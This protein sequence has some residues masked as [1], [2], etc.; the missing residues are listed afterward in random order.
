MEEVSLSDT[1]PTTESFLQALNS[2]G[3]KC[4]V[5]KLDQKWPLARYYLRLDPK[6][7]YSKL[8]SLVEDIALAM[9]PIAPPVIRPSF[10]D[11]LVIVEMMFADHPLVEFESIYATADT[12]AMP[13][14]LG[15]T[16]IDK[17]LVVDVVALPHMIV[18][19]T[20]GSG[21]SMLLHAII[22]SLTR[23]YSSVGI[24]LALIDPK[25]VEFDRYSKHPSL[26]YPVVNDVDLAIQ[27]LE[28]LKE[29]MTNR[30]K[31]FQKYKCTNITEYRQTVKKIPYIVVVV[32][33]LAD[34][35]K[36]KQFEKMLCELAQ[37]G[38]AAGIHL[39][40]ATQHPSSKVLTGEIR[41][42]FPA[43]IACKVTTR[44]HSNV[45]LDRAG[46][47]N[48]LGKGDALFL[49]EVGN[50]T[51]FR[52]AFIPASQNRVAS[53]KNGGVREEVRSEGLLTRL[54]GAL[55]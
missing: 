31:V 19:G 47:E 30:F 33:E 5:V 14:V 1:I 40:V 20:T 36:T 39:I 18:A 38:R 16:D 27:M 43:K 11:G 23:K 53:K 24:K 8:E 50:I 48:L 21:K 37:K 52:G 26:L 9:K 15:A 46:A 44:V 32:D 17:P 45:V 13:I 54:L 10:N 6:T 7:R 55:R 35:V 41:A 2:L 34:L 42:N 12:G 22:S 3:I 25:L 28:D 29:E 49:D 4:D 51:R